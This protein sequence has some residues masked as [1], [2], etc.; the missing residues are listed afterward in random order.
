MLQRR[1]SGVRKP[2]LP[3][4]PGNSDFQRALVEDLEKQQE[5]VLA[6]AKELGTYDQAKQM[7]DVYRRLI[8]GPSKFIPALNAYHPPLQMQLTP[9][10]SKAP[11]RKVRT[12]AGGKTTR[13]KYLPRS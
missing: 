12:R 8:S 3:D 10:S 9:V 7:L 13:L 6:D 4:V 5:N 2:K 11:K 1:T